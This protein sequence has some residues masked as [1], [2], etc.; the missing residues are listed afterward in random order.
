V[1]QSG[2]RA[3]V[4]KDHG[5]WWCHSYHVHM[6]SGMLRRIAIVEYTSQEAALRAAINAVGLKERN[7]YA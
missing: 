6:N 5:L 2:R 3:K 7:Y 1:I 4:Y